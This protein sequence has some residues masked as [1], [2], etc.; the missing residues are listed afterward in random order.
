M[1]FP[2]VTETSR[3]PEPVVPDPFIDDVTILAPA[4]APPLPEPRRR[5]IWD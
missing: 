1:T 2:I 3:P 5:R 4:D